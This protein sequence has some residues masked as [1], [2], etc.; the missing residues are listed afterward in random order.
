[1]KLYKRKFKKLLSK[2]NQYLEDGVYWY[3][4]GWEYQAEMYLRA[5]IHDKINFKHSYFR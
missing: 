2:K 4:F 1:M 5:S 3:V